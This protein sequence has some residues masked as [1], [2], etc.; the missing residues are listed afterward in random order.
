MQDPPYDP[1]SFAKIVTR[2][3]SREGGSA[4]AC[5]SNVRQVRVLYG[6]STP[7]M[8]SR[9]TPLILLCISPPGFVGIGSGESTVDVVMQVWKTLFEL[10]ESKKG[11]GE[12]TEAMRVCPD[13]LKSTDDVAALAD[14]ASSAWDYM[15]SLTCPSA[16]AG[17]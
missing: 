14:W 6:V 13:L 2:D 9:S 17:H 4:P 5:S 7:P 8:L 10:G 3:A 12:I 1:G 11:R 15:A 16:P